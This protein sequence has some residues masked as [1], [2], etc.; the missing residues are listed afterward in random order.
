ML[1]PVAWREIDFVYVH[2]VGISLRGSASRRN[3]TV[4]SSSEFPESYHVP[5]ELSG[6]VQP[7]FPFPTSLPIREGGGSHCCTRSARYGTLFP[8]SLFTLN[9]RL[10][11]ND[12]CRSV[13][14]RLCRK[15]CGHVI[16]LGPYLLSMTS[17][18]SALVAV[19]G[20][21]SFHF[22]FV[23]MISTSFAIC[24]SSFSS[25]FRLAVLSY[26][27]STYLER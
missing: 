10:C 14:A 22:R 4:S 18:P 5:V 15:C 6:F 13:Q 21:S 1:C 27:M 24:Y 12:R 26:S 20:F 7:L 3:V 2:S 9:L 11:A 19:P 17:S 16:G 8:F 25:S 23:P